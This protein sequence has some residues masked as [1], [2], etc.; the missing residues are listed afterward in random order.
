LAQTSYLEAMGFIVEETLSFILND[1]LS[2]P[3]IPE[4]DSHRL[5]QLC[6]KLELLKEFFITS[7]GTV[8]IIFS[9][10]S[11]FIGFSASHVLGVNSRCI[12]A[13]VV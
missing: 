7:P 10:S 4:L 3:D 2:L 11:G 12:C 8:G 13:V 1:I 6:L 9:Y 5:N